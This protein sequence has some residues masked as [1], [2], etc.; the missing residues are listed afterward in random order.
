MNEPLKFDTAMA[1]TMAASWSTWGDHLNHAKHAVALDLDQ[2]QLGGMSSPACGR[3]GAAATYL[4][5]AA[6][7]THRVRLDVSEADGHHAFQPR[8]L[9]NL[10]D[11]VARTVARSAGSHALEGH[12]WAQLDHLRGAPAAEVRSYFEGVGHPDPATVLAKLFGR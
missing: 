4:W 11:Q 9:A 12:R 10:M 1:D 8:Y 7:F 6:A 2:L 5:T 3:L